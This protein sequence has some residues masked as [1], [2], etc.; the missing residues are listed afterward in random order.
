MILLRGIFLQ[1]ASLLQQAANGISGLCTV[2][3]P[4]LSLLHI[5][6]DAVGL[7]QG[8]V[9]ADLFDAAAIAGRTSISNNDTVLRSLLSTHSSQSD[10]NH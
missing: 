5:N 2:L 9:S 7:D 6:S 1:H 3:D 4:G 10:L 8:V